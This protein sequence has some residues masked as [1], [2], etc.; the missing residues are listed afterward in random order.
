MIHVYWQTAC[1]TAVVRLLLNAITTDSMKRRNSSPIQA[2]SICAGSSVTLHERHH[3]LA[4]FQE[5]DAEGLFI[6]GH[7]FVGGRNRTVERV[8]R[9]RIVAAVATSVLEE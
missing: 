3:L 8:N 5:R 9:L 2:T 1:R 6:K 4:I 7:A